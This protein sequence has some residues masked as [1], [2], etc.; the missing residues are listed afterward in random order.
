MPSA[1][2]SVALALP[3]SHGCTH[4][5]TLGSHAISWNH[6]TCWM[7]RCCI[8]RRAE[9]ERRR[10]LYWYR[11]MGDPVSTA[12]GSLRECAKDRGCF[13]T[14]YRLPAVCQTVTAYWSADKGRLCDRAWVSPLICPE[15]SL[16]FKASLVP[17]K[18]TTRAPRPHRLPRSRVR[19]LPRSGHV[20]F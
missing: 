1:F 15:I 7:R 5:R 18:S 20:A 6:R 8:C 3:F 19:I 17:L 13:K 11:N 10:Q 14:P 12:L 16:F 2:L 9:E 4:T